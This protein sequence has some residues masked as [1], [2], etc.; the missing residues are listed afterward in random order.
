MI[1]FSAC[2]AHIC[3]QEIAKMFW[4]HI[5]CTQKC[6][7]LILI[8]KFPNWETS[9]NLFEIGAK[10][11]SKLQFLFVIT[12]SVLNPKNTN[13]QI[14]A[15]ICAHHIKYIHWKIKNNIL[16]FSSAIS[17]SLNCRFLSGFKIFLNLLE[18]K[19]ERTVFLLT[20]QLLGKIAIER[21]T[22]ASYLAWH[23]VL[24][25][26][27]HKSV[28]SLGNEISFWLN[29]QTGEKKQG[30]CEKWTYRHDTTS[31]SLAAMT[32]PWPPDTRA[33]TLST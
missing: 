8:P 13:M 10:L 22:C 11:L 17:C 9:R 32:N 25:V 30:K 18:K 1:T 19:I 20:L 28:T 3:C 14:S 7:Y 26:T 6:L 24:L 12:T 16:N 31:E 5:K 4:S 21:C 29:K 15:S 23:Y 27:Q 33:G 2:R